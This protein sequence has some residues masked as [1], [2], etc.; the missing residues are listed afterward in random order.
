ME[1]AS[2][3]SSG[4]FKNPYLQFHKKNIKNTIKPINKYKFNFFIPCGFSIIGVFLKFF[5]FTN[6]GTLVV[7][8]LYNTYIHFIF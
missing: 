6:V 8:I 2:G 1:K 7:S 5:G 3:E 4:A